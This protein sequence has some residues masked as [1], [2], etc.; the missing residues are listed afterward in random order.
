MP[1]P[2][3]VSAT[4][5]AEPFCI[6]PEKVVDVLRPPAVKV[7]VPLALLVIVPAPAIEPTV[8]ENLFKSNVPVTTKALASFIRSEAPSF[9]VPA[10]IVVAPV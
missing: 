10:E 9:N 3:L 1:E 4:D 8:S 2:D 7:G 6:T 5:V